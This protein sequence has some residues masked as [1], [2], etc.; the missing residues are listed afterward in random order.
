MSV[1]VVMSNEKEKHR[2]EGTLRAAREAG[3]WTGE[4]VWVAI[5]FH[6]DPTITER[7]NITVMNRSMI[8]LQWL[9]DLRKKYP[10][11]ESDGRELSKLIQFSKWR[12]FD[13][14]FLQWR[15]MLYLDAGTYIANP[16][17]PF[18]DVPHEGRIVAPD[19]RF[20]FND[21]DK[22]FRRQWDAKSMPEIYHDLKN[23]CAAIDP[24]WWNEKGYFLNCIWLMDTSLIHPNTQ[25]DLLVLLRRFPISKTNEMAIMNLYY[26]DQ[27]SPLP[28][29]HHG[30]RLFDWTER[31]DHKT[32]D[33]I[34]LKYPRGVE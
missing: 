33:Y 3:E 20:P 15:S 30:H 19:D 26:H 25:E 11:E 16:I 9:W 13:C 2:A 24:Q 8:D 1:V 34:L 29:T 4:L 18:F 28:E 5:G 7:W 6:P 21:P 10:F 31:F 17:A 12:V 23:Y 22:T 32:K 27:W 14:E